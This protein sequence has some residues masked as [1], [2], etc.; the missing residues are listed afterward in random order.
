MCIDKMFF[1]IHRAR[2]KI[3]TASPRVTNCSSLSKHVSC[4]VAS[5]SC[6][7]TRVMAD[8]FVVCTLAAWGLSQYADKF[9]GKDEY[10]LI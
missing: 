10:H 5:L 3:K 2:H 6:S 1:K 7:V 8:E 4:E 9:N